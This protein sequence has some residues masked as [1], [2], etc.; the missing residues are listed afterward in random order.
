MRVGTQV[1]LVHRP[2]DQLRKGA[3]TSLLS[4]LAHIEIL[5][6]KMRITFIV[7]WLL[8]CGH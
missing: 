5:H 8:P 1:S 7:L 6:N 2:I 3:G 4:N